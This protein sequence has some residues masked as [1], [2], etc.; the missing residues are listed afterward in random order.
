[1][2]KSILT[3]IILPLYLFVYG[4]FPEGFE[5][6]I[7]PP[8]GWASFDNAIGQGQS[9]QKIDSAFAGNYAAFIRYE[10]V[11]SGIAEDWLVTPQFS[12][13]PD[14]FVFSFYQRQSYIREYGTK[15]SIRISTKSQNKETDFIIIDEQVE[16]DIL[17]TYTVHEIDLS[18]YIG[19]QVYIAFV[20]NNDDGDNWIIDDVDLVGC[21]APKDLYVLNITGSGADLGWQD[22]YG[23]SW[24]IEI[25]ESGT[26][27]TGIP[28]Y[29][30]ITSN[31]F[32]WYGGEPFTE[33][34]F[35]VRS[36]CNGNESSRLTKPMSFLTN[37]SD[38]SCDYIFVFSDTYGDDWNNAFIE[39]RQ[40]GITTGTITQT[41]RGFGPFTLG[42]PMCSD[43]DFELVW[44]SGNWDQ[45]CIFKFY[46][47]YDQLYFS[48]DAGNFP[49]NNEVF[50]SN[51]AN[52]DTVTCRFPYDL[53]VFNFTSKGADFSWKEKD[54]ATK[55]D[56]EI[57]D[58]NTTPSGIPTIEGFESKIYKWDGGNP[59]TYYDFYIRAACQDNDKSDWTKI[60][61]AT[62]CEKIIQDYPYN[63]SYEAELNLPLCWNSI[64]KGQGTELWKSKADYFSGDT[65]VECRH[66]IE[67]QD[68]WLIS[69]T[70]DLT[71]LT[72]NP[73]L[74][75]DWKMS[76]YWMVYPFNKGD[77]NLRISTDN[78]ETWSDPLWS[79]ELE[80]I[81]TSFEWQTSR[82][83]LEQ[84]KNVP[85]IK[86]ALQYIAN[87]AST[88]YIDNFTIESDNNIITINESI[89]STDFIIYPN[90][91]KDKLY[92]KYNNNNNQD[93]KL[94]IIDL[95]GKKVV[96]SYNFYPLHTDVYFIDISTLTSGIYFVEIDIGIEQKY[97]KFIKR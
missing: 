72:S 76:Y 52:C 7:F 70:F 36:E 96:K 56:I 86:F 37:C 23:D 43:M 44:H 13:T 49:K 46:D 33:Y 42:Y 15:Y 54:L 17:T 57:V 81:F 8:Q 3:I 83:D 9:W 22:K 79:E 55:W 5:G 26:T 78:G 84:Y 53:E 75:F 80:T 27:P 32:T 91:V 40:N 41:E 95:M 21:I 92:I 50:F 1:M 35:Y 61:F 73:I 85:N 19:E 59:G 16:N 97:K 62:L 38:F 90:P 12:P 88:V 58:F 24:S 60:S 4:Q 51:F 64:S 2:K 48:F 87:D 74:S 71:Q 25:V 18:N 29:E 11:D 34:D 10:N 6:D 66:H 69:P 82:I 65:V 89:I 45:E 63:Q 94:N 67:D 47:S 20:M 93:V 28:N 31:P 30:N 77:L 39:I 68:I 14:K